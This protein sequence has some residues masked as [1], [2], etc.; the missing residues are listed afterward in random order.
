MIPHITDE[1][2]EWIRKMQ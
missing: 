2:K 1:I